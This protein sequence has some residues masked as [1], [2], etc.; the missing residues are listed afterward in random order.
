MDWITENIA[1]GNYFEAQDAQV[2]RQFKSVLGLVPTLRDLDDSKKD[3]IA[4]LRG[5]LEIDEAE[6]D[7][8]LQRLREELKTKRIEV[9]ELIDGPGNDVALFRRAVSVLAELTKETPP[10]LV[11]CHAGRSRSPAVV[12]G[13]LMKSLRID[14]S[15]ALEIVVQKRETYIAPALICLL[16]SLE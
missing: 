11:H 14:A 12:A 6:F 7:E 4:E 15:Q 10:V 5:L 3:A 8:T 16:D 9:V 1:I 13:Y 2:L